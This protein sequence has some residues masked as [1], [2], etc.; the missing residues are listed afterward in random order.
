MIEKIYELTVGNNKTAEKVVDDDHVNINHVILNKDE[1]LPLHFSNSN[2][3]LVIVRG[4][5][6]LALNEG[7]FATY[8]FGQIINVPYKTKMNVSNTKEPVLEFFVVKT[9]NPRN[10][11]K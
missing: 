4:N 3:Y 5:L 9:P 11:N 10:Y 2:V 1:A 6:T 8:K 7:E